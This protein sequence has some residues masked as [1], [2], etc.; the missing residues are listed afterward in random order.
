MAHNEK[1]ILIMNL[2]LNFDD[3]N[4][5]IF[6]NIFLIILNIIFIIQMILL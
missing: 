1:N 6:I 4:T 2:F 3:R 5:P